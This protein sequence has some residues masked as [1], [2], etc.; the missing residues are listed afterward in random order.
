VPLQTA[1]HP[2]AALLALAL[3]ACTATPVPAPEPAPR[4]APVEWAEIA[5]QPRPAPGQRIAYDTGPHRFGELRLPDGR[6]PHP[7]VVLIHGGCWQ[8]EYDLEHVAPLAAALTESG[9]ATW[10]LEY[11]RI[12]ATGGGWTATFDDVSRGTD[13]LRALAEDHPLDLE[14]VVLAGHSA[15]GHLALWL[16]ARPNLPAESPL[17][18]PDPLPVRGVVALAAITD[19]RAYGEGNGDCNASVAQLLGGGPDAVPER[20][21]AASPV[22]LVPLDVPV[23]LVHGELDAIVPLEQSERFHLRT[24]RRAP[25]GHARVTVVGG[26][27]HFDVI[28]PFAPAWSLVEGAVRD[29]LQ[30]PWR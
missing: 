11:R 9:Y 2:R 8:S 30:W 24:L 13:H 20:Y 27:G 10:T 22:E 26:A 4:R 6:G 5:A 3:G 17:H 18:A 23:R 21:A 7:V 14:R 16:A 1:P 19:L 28:A 12:G 25:Q 15:G 29:L